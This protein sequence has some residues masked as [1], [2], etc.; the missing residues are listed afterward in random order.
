MLRKTMLLATVVALVLIAAATTLASSP[1]DSNDPAKG[2]LGKNELGK[3]KDFAGL[4]DIGGGREVYMEC[5]G[6][7]RPTVV[8]ISGFAGSHEDWTHLRDAGGELNPSDDAV[9]P[10]VGEFARVCAYDRPG[11]TRMDGTLSPSTPV[12]QP[13][14]AKEGAADLHALLRAAKQKGPYVLVAHSW[15][16]LIARRNTRASTP[17]TSPASSSWTPALSSCRTR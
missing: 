7:G 2:T 9:F 11:T 15:G 5:R 13:T 8:L 4:V 6:K 1:S 10:E 3:N 16:G 12:R 14:T 17:K